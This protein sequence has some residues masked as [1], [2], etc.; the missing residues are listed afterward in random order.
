LQYQQGLAIAIA[1]CFAIAAILAIADTLAIAA[2]ALQC[3]NFSKEVV[4]NYIY[5]K[6][7]TRVY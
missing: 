5:S 3:N 4:L 2:K 1:N 6:L 7:P